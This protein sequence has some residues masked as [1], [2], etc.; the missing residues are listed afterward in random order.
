[1]GRAATGGSRAGK[2]V[3]WHPEVR[4]NW[5]LP[6]S[7]FRKHSPLPGVSS[8]WFEGNEESIKFD[9]GKEQSTWRY[10]LLTGGNAQDR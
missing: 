8:W 3:H 7:L 9:C 10:S 6:L 2:A 5:C 4:V 1:M